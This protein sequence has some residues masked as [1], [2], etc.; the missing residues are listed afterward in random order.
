L[1]PSGWF[2]WLIWDSSFC[3]FPRPV[4]I[5][6]SFCGCKGRKGSTYWCNENVLLLLASVFLIYVVS[7]LWTNIFFVWPVSLGLSFFS[8]DQFHFIS[9]SYYNWYLDL[10]VLCFHVLIVVAGG[11]TCLVIHFSFDYRHA[12]EGSTFL[13]LALFYS[14]YQA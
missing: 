12:E 11:R 6:T 10:S 1:T 2:Y 7:H 8:S 9:Y 13:E 5:R 3:W 4:L 14:A